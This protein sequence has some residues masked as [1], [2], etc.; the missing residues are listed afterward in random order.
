MN[1]DLKKYGKKKNINETLKGISASK[2]VPRSFYALL[3]V[4]YWVAIFYIQLTSRSQGVYIIFGNPVPITLFTGIC[5]SF[6]NIFLLM[7]VVLFR[8]LGFFTAVILCLIQFPTLFISFFI[9]HNYSSIPGLFSNVATMVAISIIFANNR[10]I[11]KYQEKMH[12]LAVVDE[13]TGLPNRYACTVLMDDLIKKNLKFALVSINLNNFKTINDTLG[14]K[15]G[16]EMLKEI[17][18]RWKILADSGETKTYDFVARLGSDE[19]SIIIRAYEDEEEILKTIDFYEKELE[20]KIM[21]NN[22]DFFMSACFGIAEFPGDSPSSG[23]LFSCADAALHEAKRKGGN[24]SVLHFTPELLKTERYMAI[25][26]RIRLALKEN[27][28][29]TYLQPQYDMNHKL[30]GFE[31]LAR[32]KDE[33]GNFIP[34]SEFIPVAENAG[35]I[36]KVDNYVLKNAA[37]FLADINKNSFEN[38]KISSNI[39]V[40]HLMKNDFID[41]IKSIIESVNVKPSDFKLEITESVMIDSDEKAL[42]KIEEIKDLG[43]QVAIDD[44]GTGYSSLSYLHKF[45]ANMLK[46]DKSFIDVMNDNEANEKYVAMIV[47]IGHVLNLEVISEG[48]ETEKQIETLKSIGCDYIQGYV[49]GKPL[50]L[51]EARKLF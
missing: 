14:H 6:A 49:W 26:R 19:Y 45:P 7:M 37:E 3:F 42:Q 43:M 25:E 30:C 21:I 46:I 8:R 29:I 13:L 10:R 1:D 50:P 2:R 41:E 35:L 40:L 11:G 34:P 31:A 24:T 17:A 12:K 16:D 51:E 23:A 27:Q 9:G 48:V 18:N 4:L 5:S 22:C 33:D 44:F 39:S 20:R 28:I 15:A 38:I 32:L 47:S 36:D